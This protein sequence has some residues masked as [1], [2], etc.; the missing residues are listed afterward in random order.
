MLGIGLIATFIGHSIGFTFGMTFSDIIIQNPS[1]DW[2]VVVLSLF[3][4]Q[5][6]VTTLNAVIATEKFCADLFPERPHNPSVRQL[7]GGNNFIIPD[8]FYLP[9]FLCFKKHSQ[10]SSP[11]QGLDFFIKIGGCPTRRELFFV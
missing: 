6:P 10:K 3:L 5:L 9:S 7:A 8:K 1:Q 11:T 4:P 2:H